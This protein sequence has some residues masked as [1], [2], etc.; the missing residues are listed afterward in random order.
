[1]NLQ[2]E[3]D[4]KIKQRQKLIQDNIRNNVF[5]STPDGSFNIKLEELNAEIGQLQSAILGEI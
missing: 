1:M 2:K 5:N 3:L 4:L